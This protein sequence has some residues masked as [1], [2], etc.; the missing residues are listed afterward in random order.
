MP[1]K[2]QNKTMNLTLP[3]T[4][5]MQTY[6]IVKTKS[7]LLVNKS[8]QNDNEPESIHNENIKWL[9]ACSIGNVILGAP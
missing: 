3:Y 8:R 9:I 1:V 7:N 5:K 2:K 6:K 4:S